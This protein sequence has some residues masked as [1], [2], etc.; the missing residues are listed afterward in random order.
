MSQSIAKKDKQNFFFLSCIRIASIGIPSLGIGH[1]LSEQYGPGVAIPSIFVGNLILWIIGIAVVSVTNKSNINGVQN[2]K[3]F[4]GTTGTLLISITLL[5]A[6]FDWFSFQINAT[7]HSFSNI[8]PLNFDIKKNAMVRIGTAL[9]LLSALLALGG[10]RLLKWTSVITLPCLILYIGY[11]LAHS[12]MSIIDSFSWGLSFSAVLTIVLAFLAGV[13]CLPTFFRYSSSLANSYL[14][15]TIVVL[16]FTL[17]QTASIL[18]KFD[19]NSYGIIILN[20]PSNILSD[21]LIPSIFIFLI[22]ICNNLMNI[23]FASAFYETFSPRFYGTKGHAIMGLMGTATYA[24]VQISPSIL[25]LLNL[26]T[27]Y[28]FNLSCVLLIAFILRIIVKHKSS[29]IEQLINCSAWIIGCI[30]GTIAKFQNPGE[31]FQFLFTGISAS[32]LFFLVVVF[33]KETTG[34]IQDFRLQRTSK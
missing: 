25:F 9:G 34:A 28:I 10:M 24:F 18:I 8:L 29:R 20:K 12:D 1:F 30:V 26:I 15:L 27:S 13:I 3:N 7:I 16:F 2:I 32:A 21:F 11:V 17:I 6:C 23:Y 5:I 4:I 31:E 22:C 19:P 14:A 33:M